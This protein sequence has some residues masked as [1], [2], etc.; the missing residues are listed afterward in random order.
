MAISWTFTKPDGKRR[1]TADFAAY[2]VVGATAEEDTF[3]E[4]EITFTSVFGFQGLGNYELALRY[5]LFTGTEAEYAALVPD[6]VAKADDDVTTFVQ[7]GV[8]AINAATS[9][10][11]AA[12]ASADH[13]AGVAAA[14]AFC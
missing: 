13:Q 2:E 12:A 1:W 11:N 5:G 8:A 3:D 7:N 6:A 14:A 9:E 10:A 4:I